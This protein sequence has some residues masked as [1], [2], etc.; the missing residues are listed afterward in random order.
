MLSN[1]LK[2]E[3][4][5]KAVERIGASAPLEWAAPEAV[6]PQQKASGADKK[7]LGAWVS[8]FLRPVSMT[9]VAY[10]ACL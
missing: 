4:G 2:A 10:R 1:A 8:V 7:E 9:T 3:G 6:L 5:A